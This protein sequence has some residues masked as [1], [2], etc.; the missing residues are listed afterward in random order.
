[1]KMEFKKGDIIH[2]Q[3]YT[4]RRIKAKVLSANFKRSFGPSNSKRVV[5]GLEGISSPLVTI[6]GPKSIE[7]SRFFSPVA[8]EDAFKD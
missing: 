7:E 6:T 4:D 2:F 1:M 8:P 3:N 5:Y